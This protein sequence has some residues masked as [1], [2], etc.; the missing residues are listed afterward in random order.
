MEH[1]TGDD[2]IFYKDND[3]IM[4][5][6]YT[7]D[8]ILLKNNLSPMTTFN[9]NQSGGDKVSSGFENLAIPAGL[10]YLHKTKINDDKEESDILSDIINKYPEHVTLDDD[11]HEKL[12]KLVDMS[13]PKKQKTRKNKDK[14]KVSKGK[15]KSRK[16]IA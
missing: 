3:R 1:F 15:K 13:K 16:N 12:F 7:I 8:S 11:L 14:N 5:G 4:S 9:T 2:L 6:G 10:L